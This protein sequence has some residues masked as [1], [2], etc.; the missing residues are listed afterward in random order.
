MIHSHKLDESTASRAADWSIPPPAGMGSLPARSAMYP[1]RL[2]K[3]SD[4]EAEAYIATGDILL[5][6]DPN[7]TQSTDYC[8]GLFPD[9]ESG[10][11]SGVQSL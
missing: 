5:A 3:A 11:G 2:M 8:W 1:S 9:G 7:R 10:A 6:A 4:P